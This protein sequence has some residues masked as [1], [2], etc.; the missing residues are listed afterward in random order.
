MSRLHI[1]VH[2]D[3]LE[4]SLRFYTALFGQAPSRV[5]S[6]YAKWMLEDPRVNFAVS[7]GS[8]RKGVGHLGIQVESE[9]ELEAVS[10]RG[11]EATN[12]MLV[13]RG[14]RCC[15]ATGDK[16]W[17]EDADGVQWEL[18]H[19]KGRLDEAGHGADEAFLWSGSER[20]PT[21]HPGCGCTPAQDAGQVAS[22]CSS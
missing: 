3:D 20:Q 4:A 7:T 12:D 8:E 10:A 15:Y 11:R 16:V 14:A 9:E 1:H 5:E 22:C 17:I 21:S 19:T 13:E 18:F 2:V 6:G